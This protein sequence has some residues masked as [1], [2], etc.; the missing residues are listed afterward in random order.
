[1]F[2]FVCCVS[3]LTGFWPPT[4]GLPDRV[5]PVATTGQMNRRNIEVTTERPADRLQ[6][7]RT[8]SSESRS[9]IRAG[10]E[11]LAGGRGLDHPRHNAARIITSGKVSPRHE[12]HHELPCGLFSVGL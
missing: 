4:P 7:A 6:E 5:V 2:F 3:A 9:K 10:Y 12:D 11:A 1:V 8:S